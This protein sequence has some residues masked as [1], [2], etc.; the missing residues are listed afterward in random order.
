MPVPG[1]VGDRLAGFRIECPGRPMAPR[2]E[3]IAD[4]CGSD[5]LPIGQLSARRAHHT[6]RSAHEFEIA[7]ALAHPAAI[8]HWSALHHHGLTEQAPRK[9]FM[10]RAASGVTRMIVLPVTLPSGWMNEATPASSSFCT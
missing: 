6:G 8:S 4:A 2:T 10:V 7:M 1:T 5:D 3:Q 9:V